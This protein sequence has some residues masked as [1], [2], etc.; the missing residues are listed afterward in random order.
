MLDADD[1]T[2]TLV[3]IFDVK[4]ISFVPRNLNRF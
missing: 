3:F 1:S 2:V 4:T